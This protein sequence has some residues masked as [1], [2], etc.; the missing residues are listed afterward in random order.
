[1]LLLESKHYVAVIIYLYAC[2]SIRL[3][4]CEPENNTLVLPP[5][6]HS[7]WHIIS[8]SYLFE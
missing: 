5:A 6:C 4:H 8:M 2:L 7:A 3:V 1:M